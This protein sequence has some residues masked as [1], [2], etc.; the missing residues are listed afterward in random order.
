MRLSKGWFVCLAL[1]VGASLIA[2]TSSAGA[3]LRI[4]LRRSPRASLRLAVPNVASSDIHRATEGRV[5]V[6]EKRCDLDGPL[7]V[8]KP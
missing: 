6:S 8:A 1:F 4:M 2:A 5:F 3:I 7:L